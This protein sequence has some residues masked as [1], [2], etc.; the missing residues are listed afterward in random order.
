[1]NTFTAQDLVDE[2]ENLSNYD[3]GAGYLGYGDE[4]LNFAGGASSFVEPIKSTKTYQVQIT[5]ASG[6]T[7]VALLCPGLIPNRVGLIATGAFNDKNNTAGL[8]ASTSSPGSIEM[9]N[10]FMQ[11]FPSLVAGVKL[12][13]NNIVQISQSMTIQQESP[14]RIHDSLIIDW[15][16]FQSEN[17]FNGNLLTVDMPF[18]MDQ[19]TRIEV[20]I[21][22]GA[23]LGIIFFVGVSLNTA[24]ALREKVDRANGNIA[25]LG[26]TKVVQ[27]ALSGAK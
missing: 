11:K 23:T 2:A 24:M 22:A 26:G 3:G 12:V 15:G 20:P 5:N 9:F 1:M 13:S 10:W 19:Q 27:N 17:S 18:Y 25:R 8:S 14:F 7:L 6:G 16:T 21:L 4:F